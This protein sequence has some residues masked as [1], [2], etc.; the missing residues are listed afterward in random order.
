MDPDMSFEPDFTPP[1][2]IFD[3]LIWLG[4]L[5]SGLLLG[6]AAVLSS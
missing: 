2:S 3:K 5:L 6:A 1:S 4:L